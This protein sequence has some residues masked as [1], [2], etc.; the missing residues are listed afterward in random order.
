[1]QQFFTFILAIVLMFTAI[2]CYKDD[3]L[4]ARTSADWIE[5]KRWTIPQYLVTP[6]NGITWVC[7]GYAGHILEFKALANE[8]SINTGVVTRTGSWAVYEGTAGNILQIQVPE[9]LKDVYQLS[10]QWLVVEQTM[11]TLKL[12]QT[13][14][15]M[16]L[17]MNLKQF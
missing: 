10:G 8:M 6:A 3:G 5:N 16:I 11:T 4:D 7:E 13:V 9:V 14:N 17:E 12:R 1:M 15:G 2:S